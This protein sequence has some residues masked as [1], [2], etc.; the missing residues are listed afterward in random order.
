MLKTKRNS[1]NKLRKQN[2]TQNE[3]DKTK[4]NSQNKMKQNTEEI[5]RIPSFVFHRIK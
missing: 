1:Q 2:N 3:T 5:F 4:R